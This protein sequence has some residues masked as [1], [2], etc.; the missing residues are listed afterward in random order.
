MRYFSFLSN[1]DRTFSKQT[2]ETLIRQNASSDLGLHC[3]SMSHKEAARLIKVNSRSPGKS[4]RG[5]E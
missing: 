4:L 5:D 1:F 2:V 3:L